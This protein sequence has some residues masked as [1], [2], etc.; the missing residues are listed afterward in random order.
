MLKRLYIDN[1]KCLV[2]FDLELQPLQLI[3]GLNGTG[4][5]SVFEVLSKIRAFV[6]GDGRTTELFRSHSLTQWQRRA[7]QS[8]ELTVE[9][10]GGTY[11]Y[12]LEIEHEVKQGKNRIRKE[13]LTFDGRPLIASERGEVKLYRDDHSEG[14]SFPLDWT[15]SALAATA[16]RQD[17]TR[18]TWFKD[19]LGRVF[20]IQMDPFRMSALSEQEVTHP[21]Q[22]LADFAS[23]YRHLSQEQPGQNAALLDTL[24]DVLD[25]FDSL[26]L[27]KSGEAR[28]L[29]AAFKVDPGEQAPATTVE[30]DFPDLSDGQRAL[31]ALYTL[32]HFAVVPDATLCIDEPENFIAL[33]E[34]QPWLIS[35]FDRV[36]EQN[37]QALFV[38]H[39][40]ELINYLSAKSGIRLERSQGG[41]VRVSRQF[42]DPDS[43]LPPAEVIARGWD[44]G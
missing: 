29:L 4:K 31:I 40:P 44:R 11:T 5:S 30:F 15:R 13:E 6:L 32:L 23:W 14:P 8:F 37:S 18:L 43:G 26:R 7:A 20:I 24:R 2:N 41:P 34:I 12:K 17:N 3:L 10:N 35:I 1:Y 39:H 27:A 22:D 28:M 21:S 25:G 16:P 9:G 33:P 42:L 38:S 19:H 36:Q